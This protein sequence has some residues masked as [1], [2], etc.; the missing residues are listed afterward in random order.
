M[1]PSDELRAGELLS[2]KPTGL[3]L[4]FLSYDAGPAKSGDENKPGARP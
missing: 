4:L 3:G 2:P 1:P